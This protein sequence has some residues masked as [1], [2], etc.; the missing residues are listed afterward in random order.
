VNRVGHFDPGAT[1]EQD[2]GAPPGTDLDNGAAIERMVALFY[3]RLLAD[4][5]LA[6]VF[7]DVARI[8]LD[9]HLPVI[10]AYWKKMLL[11]EPGYRRHMMARHRAVHQRQPLT[12]LH[13]ERWLGHFT[14]TLDA[15]FQG[16]LTDRARRL[17]ARII[18][19]LYAQLSR[20][21]G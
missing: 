20:R 4:P 3:A 18:D 5:L 9:Q 14:A 16:P 6:P 11:G 21:H 8:D 12:G 7:V 17:A 1:A 13:H 2:H 10:A 15:H 19:N